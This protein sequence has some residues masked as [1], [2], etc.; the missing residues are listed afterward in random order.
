MSLPW[1][2][3]IYYL[4]KEPESIEQMKTYF[5]SIYNRDFNGG[6]IYV[7]GHSKRYHHACKNADEA[8][9]AATWLI[10]ESGQAYVTANQFARRYGQGKRRE[11]NLFGLDH[12]VIDV[13]TI[14]D[15]IYPYSE[16][17][18][19][20]TIY[21]GRDRTIKNPM[22]SYSDDELVELIKNQCISDGVPI[23]NAIVC[24]GSGG[25]HLYYQ[26]ERL[27]KQAQKS[28]QAVAYKLAEMLVYWERTETFAFCKVDLR[29]M[30]A[31]RLFRV[32]GSIHGDTLKRATY[33][34]VREELY[35]FKEL[36]EEVIDLDS[37]RYEYLVENVK[38]NIAKIRNG[39]EEETERKKSE[40]KISNQ[41][42]YKVFTKRTPEALATNR[43]NDMKLLADSGF[44]FENCREMACFIVR[45][46]ARVLDW[47]EGEIMNYLYALNSKF[48]APLPD[49][50]L[51]TVS[52]ARDHYKMKNSTIRMILDLGNDYPN[53]FMPVKEK[54]NKGR[55][56]LTQCHKKAIAALVLLGK[57]IS[58]I[59]KELGYSIS[60][61][62]RRRTQ[63]NK[64]EG[65]EYWA[66]LQIA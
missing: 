13:D 21:K 44:G 12:I 36:Q 31:S 47:S 37:W 26:F 30:D 4:A 9:K 39:L 52:K 24:T 33:H 17:E 11:R 53:V 25:F 14:D 3:P 23:P 62:K 46:N 34:K 16:A 55:K 18:K 7:T 42:P 57:S 27:P 2:D 22:N 65:F 50:E 1:Y 59:A 19:E 38:R 45:N 56:K 28:V 10:Q 15:P 6:Y 63:M 54:K 32:P 40:K 60:L 49:I 64:A 48:Y 41:R 5:N 20:P 61:V 43:L 29:T 51:R 58:Q 35:V 66:H 8:I